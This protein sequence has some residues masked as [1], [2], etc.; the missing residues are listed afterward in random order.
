MHKLDRMIEEAL[1]EEDR[2]ILEETRELGFFAQFTRQLAG[3]N[4]WVSWMS[5]GAIF[6]YLGLALWCGYEFFS[7]TEPLAAIKWGLGAALSVVVIGLFKLFMFGEMQANRI[8]RELKRVELML[9]KH[10]G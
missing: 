4:A 6:V 2:E 7:A 10:D 1:A 9:A 5:T 8:V 3:P